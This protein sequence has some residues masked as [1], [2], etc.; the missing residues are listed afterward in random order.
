MAGNRWNLPDLGFGIGLR[1]VHFT[2]ILE[3]R[4]PVDWFEVLSENYMDTGGRPLYV[5]DFVAEHY[6]VVLH[7]VSLSIGSTDPL[8][9]E[10][11]RKLKTLAGRT[12]ARWVSDHLCWTGVSGLNVHDLL[13]MPYTDESLRHTVERVRMVQDF[14]E[15]PLILEN[16]STYL[17]F[18]HSTWTEWE[19]LS[20][21]AEQADCGIL[22]D[23]NNVYVSAFNHG[24]DPKAYLDAIPPDLVV[25]NHLAGH[26]NK[27]THI[28]D[29]HSDHVIDKVWELYRYHSSHTGGAS[30]LLEWDE[31]I[32]GFDVVHAEALKARS[33]RETSQPVEMVAGHAL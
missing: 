10:Y 12:R 14:L 31:S 26:T 16:P 22:L 9:R 20:A 18:G 7:G 15:R 4:P 1:S 11:L 25:Q 5:L 33:Y 28:L 24:F 21:L 8:N 29:T 6:P 3:R 32:P 17:E 23:V 19:F 13:P 2:H 27:G 30:T